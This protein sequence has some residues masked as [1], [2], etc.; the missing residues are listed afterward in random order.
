MFR[1]Y[2]H[3]SFGKAWTALARPVAIFMVCVLLTH[4]AWRFLFITGMENRQYAEAVL[5][6]GDAGATDRTKD[7]L[8]CVFA[9][10]SP[11]RTDLRVGYIGF[12]NWDVT[13]FFA[14]L[15]GLTAEAALATC[16]LWDDCCYLLKADKGG[17]SAYAIRNSCGAGG[18]DFDII[19][20][21]TG[22]KQALVW[23]AVLLFAAGGVCWRKLAFGLAGLV[24]MLLFNIVRI[25]VVVRCCADDAGLFQ[26]LHNGV[27]RYLYYGLIFVLWLVWTEYAAP[28][29]LKYACDE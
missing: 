11:N 1:L 6:D 21:C 23:M 19:W 10:Q 17:V 14:P 22:F 16:N 15:C 24:V 8:W 4:F 26:L 5:A 28:R 13:P 3:F 25:A 2:P 9:G 20:G 27:F 12:L 7:A 18:A 29:T